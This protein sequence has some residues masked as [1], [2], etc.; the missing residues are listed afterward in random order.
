MLKHWQKPNKIVPGAYLASLPHL[1]KT[2][3]NSNY[4]RKQ[5]CL[6][7]L[8]GFWICPSFWYCPKF[9]LYFL[10]YKLYI[11]KSCSLFVFCL[12]WKLVFVSALKVKNTFYFA[13]NW[14]FGFSFLAPRRSIHPLISVHMTLIVA[15]IDI[16]LT[17]KT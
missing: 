11:R 15:R 14:Y 16:W 13:K 9:A 3:I 12:C 1:F 2:I 8:A 17:T 6:W 5:L 10:A 7:F 4:Y